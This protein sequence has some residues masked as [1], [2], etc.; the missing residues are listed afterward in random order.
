MCGQPFSTIARV[1]LGFIES[2]IPWYTNYKTPSENTKEQDT[3]LQL[4]CFTVK[5]R[6]HKPQQIIMDD[7]ISVKNKDY[8]DLQPAHIDPTKLQF[9]SN[10]PNINP[11]DNILSKMG[12]KIKKGPG[13]KITTKSIKDLKTNEY[14]RYAVQQITL[15]VTSTSKRLEARSAYDI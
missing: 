13:W 4:Y 9:P 15:H 11:T 2:F 6:A 8:Y 12:N 5:V 14:R 3:T 1:I 7:H 10:K